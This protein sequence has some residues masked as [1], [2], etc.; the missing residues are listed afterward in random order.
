MPYNERERGLT[1][2]LQTELNMSSSTYSD[3]LQQLA[4]LPILLF[5]YHHI[6]LTDE[7][8]IFVSA[9]KFT[10]SLALQSKKSNVPFV[11]AVRCS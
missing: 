7:V 6:G 2:S 9:A 4:I 3:K 1:C 8:L 5:S 11:A 10:S